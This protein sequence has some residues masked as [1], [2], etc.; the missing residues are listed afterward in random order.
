MYSPLVAWLFAAYSRLSPSLSMVAWQLTSIGAMALC[1]LLLA[2]VTGR[3]FPDT[4]W[5]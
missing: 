3:S 1:A 2:P 5:T 4:F